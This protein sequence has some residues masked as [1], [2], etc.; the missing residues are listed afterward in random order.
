M[1]SSTNDAAILFALRRRIA[2]GAFLLERE[3][4]IVTLWFG[5][6]GV[7]RESTREQMRADG[8]YRRLYE[9]RQLEQ[10]YARRVNGRAMKHAARITDDDSVES[11]RRYFDGPTEVVRAVGV[12]PTESL[13]SEA[14]AFTCLTT[15]GEEMVGP[16]G[17]EPAKSLATQAS[18][19]ANLTTAR[20]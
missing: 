13:A 12:E 3:D 5:L 19:F 1:P 14:S 20:K 16:A 8:Y 18:A 17:F 10:R 2:A 6:A 11:D 7:P 9:Y 15:H 4:P